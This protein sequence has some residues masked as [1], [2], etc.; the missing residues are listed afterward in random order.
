MIEIVSTN[1]LMY[2]DPAATS[3]LISSITVIA[4]ALGATFIIFW[5]KFKKWFTATFHFNKISNKNLEEELVVTDAT[6]S[7]D[8]PSKKDKIKK[9]ETEEDIKLKKYRKSLRYKIKK[10]DEENMGNY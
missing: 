1:N 9:Q 2:I 8:Y 4:A 10:D 7:Y 6:Y 5:R 3:A